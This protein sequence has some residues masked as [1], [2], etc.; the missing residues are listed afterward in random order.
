MA[1]WKILADCLKPGGLMK[2]GLYSELARKH[3]VKIRQEISKACIGSSD[4]AIKSLRKMVMTS[5]EDHYTLITTS[6]DFYS[7]SNLKDLLFHVQEHRFTIP[8]IQEC[9]SQLGL[10]FCGFEP[11]KTVTHFKKKNTGVDDTYDL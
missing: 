11:A 7:M 3:I 2:L 8:Q 5:N 9:L 10:N 1:G 4:A 6:S